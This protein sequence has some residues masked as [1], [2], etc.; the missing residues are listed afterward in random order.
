MLGAVGIWWGL[1][2]A[3]PFMNLLVP[4]ETAVTGHALDTGLAP[5][6]STGEALALT[7]ATLAAAA[8][9]FWKRAA[10]AEALAGLKRRVP[11]SGDRAYDAAMNG[12]AAVAAWQTRRLQSGVQRH[13]LLIVFATLGLSLA[14]TLWLK[15]VVPGPVRL[16]ETTFLDWS[17]AA[18]VAAASV[19][20]IRSRSRLLGITALGVVGVATALIFL[21]FGA[22]DVAM[23]QFI[24]ETLVTVIVAIV[25]LKLPDFRKEIWPSKPA[26]LRNGIVAV[27][28][29]VGVTL[30]LLAVT[31]SP[32]Q[33]DLREYFERTAVP[34]G[35][36]RNIVNVILVDFR[37]LDTLGEITVLAIAGAAVFALLLPASRRRE[38]VPAP[39]TGSAATRA[40]TGHDSIMNT[41]ILRETTRG[42]VPLIL[43]FSVFLLVRGHDQ[44]GGGFVGG[45]VASIAFS[46]YAVVCGPQAARRLLRADP[47]AVGAAGLA[48][49][50]ASGLAGSIREGAPFLTGQWPTIGGLSIGTPVIFDVGVYLVVVGV[51]LTFVLGIKEQ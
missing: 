26:R 14:V 13:Y 48:V 15:D 6:H 5:W 51:V 11:L 2:P 34:G 30:A 23:T 37:A 22:P 1:A 8:L 42:L 50:I 41:M 35:H 31:G 44:P 21:S 28:V 32:P 46:L 20:I 24:V 16:A 25:L 39:G 47:R 4:A 12:I 36:G 33:P 7:L 43:V 3:F 18:L 38:D 27:T 40:P 10:V 9:G 17:L 29:G 19:V 49:A 45:L